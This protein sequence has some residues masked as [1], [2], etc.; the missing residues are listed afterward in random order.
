M[1]G[2]WTE[3][4]R[5]DKHVII[6]NIFGYRY[7]DNGGWVDGGRGGVHSTNEAESSNS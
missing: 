5:C 6:S 2:L 4:S 1:N 3:G 7:V